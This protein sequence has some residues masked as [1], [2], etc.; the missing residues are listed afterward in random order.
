M[1]QKV[2]AFVFR[3][4]GLYMFMAL[5]AS[6]AIKSYMGGTT[7]F[8]FLLAGLW[9]T[10]M[11]QAFR[12]YSASYLWGRQAVAKIEAE[13]LCTAGPYGYIRNPLYLGNLLIGIGLCIAINEW[14][15]YALFLVSY[16]FVYSIVVPYEE[17][18]LQER[19][20]TAYAEYKTQTGR[21][22]PRLKRYKGGDEVTPNY[23]AGVLGEIH[24]PII[25]AIIL[26]II[27]LLYVR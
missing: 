22:L 1:N 18:F 25:L 2:S 7:T 26:I 16:A 10:A 23:K 17:K 12:M 20:G 4:R 14:Y 8:L 9:V 19:F 5:A 21:L 24:V 6:M 3:T 27:H 13:F 15:A 11:V